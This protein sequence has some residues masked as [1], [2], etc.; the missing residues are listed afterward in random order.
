MDSAPTH[1][2]DDILRKAIHWTNDLISSSCA[3]GD[4]LV[5]IPQNSISCD[6]EQGGTVQE[7]ATIATLFLPWNLCRS[8]A[9]AAPTGQ[10]CAELGVEPREEFREI[11]GHEI[12]D[13]G[14]IRNRLVVRVAM[15]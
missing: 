1:F 10:L 2:L 15:V 14:R 13:V 9:G 5:M 3:A 4:E 8:L 6:K 12:S 11:V 7:R